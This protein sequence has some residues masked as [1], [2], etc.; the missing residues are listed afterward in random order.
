MDPAHVHP[1]HPT[2]CSAR[3]RRARAV[4]ARCARAPRARGMLKRM[5][6]APRP[7]LMAKMLLLH[8]RALRVHDALR[9]ALRG[10]KGVRATRREHRR[11]CAKRCCRRYTHVDPPAPLR[12]RARPPLAGSTE[13]VLHRQRERRRVTDVPGPQN[14]EHRGLRAPPPRRDTRT[15]DQEPLCLI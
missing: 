15:A 5:L 6:L 9:G 12:D 3:S 4:R 8:A 2:C 10:P 14:D 11:C 1:H 7:L 13:N